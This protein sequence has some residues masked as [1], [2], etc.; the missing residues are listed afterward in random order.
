MRP[1]VQRDGIGVGHA[2]LVFLEAGGDVRMG[3]GIDIR[4][5]PQADRRSDAQFAGHAVQQLE[6]SR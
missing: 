5:D 2:K 6:F 4:V 3:F 1:A